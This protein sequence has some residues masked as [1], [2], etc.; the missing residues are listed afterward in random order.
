MFEELWGQAYEEEAVPDPHAKY[1]AHA[2]ALHPP[3]GMRR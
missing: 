2:A 1:G 3:R